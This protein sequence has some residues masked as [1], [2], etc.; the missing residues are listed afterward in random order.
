MAVMT[1]TTMVRSHH[2]SE[3]T[4]QQSIRPYDPLPD[5]ESHDGESQISVYNGATVLAALERGRKLPERTKDRR[6]SVLPDTAANVAPQDTK[7]AWYVATNAQLAYWVEKNP[8]EVLRMIDALR[9]DRDEGIGFVNLLCLSEG[10]NMN[11]AKDLQASQNRVT[12]VVKQRDQALAESNMNHRNYEAH[13]ALVAQLKAEKLALEQELGT[14]IP[15]H[16][17]DERDMGMENQQHT[18]REIRTNRRAD[19]DT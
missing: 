17:G 3:E 10:T 2:G 5:E 9:A 19:R 12:V 7:G 14:M 11:L 6:K 16:R 8:T 13:V 18:Q 4:P 15:N 1:V